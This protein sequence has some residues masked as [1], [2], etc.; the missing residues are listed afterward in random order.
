MND[1]SAILQKIQEDARQ[2]GEAAAAAAREKAGAITESYRQ[3]AA[4]ETAK[5][6][7]AAKRQAEAIHQRAASQ[8][9]IETR[10]QK[11]Q[12]RRQ[13]IDAAFH[14]AMERMGAEKGQTAI[15]GDQVFTDILG[16]NRA[17]IS[18]ILVEPIRLAG[19]PGRYLRYAAEWPFRLLSGRGERL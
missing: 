5:V 8:T 10:N 11:L 16:G 13:A 2:Y 17:G 18:T 12:V 7:D 9:G 3:E 14:K 15:V 4:A 1:I 19:N 6:L